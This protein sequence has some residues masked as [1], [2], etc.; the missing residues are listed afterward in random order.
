MADEHPVPSEHARDLVAGGYDTH[1]HA[2][3]DIMQRRIT[4]VDLVARFAAVGMAGFVLKSHYGCTAERAEVV[5]SVAPEADVLGA[6]TLNGPVGGLNP[7]AVE[8]AARQGARV[9][10]MPTVD[11]LNQRTSRAG[12]PPGAKT[13]LWAAVQDDLAAAGIMADPIAVLDDSGEVLPAVRDV[14]AVT[15]RHGMVLATGHLGTAEIPAVVDAAISAGVRTIVITHPEFTSQ[16]MAVAPQRELA[17]RGVLLERCF[18]TPYSGKVSWDEWLSHI[19]EVGPEHSVLS[20]DLGQPFNPPIEDGLALC[21][22]RLLE[23]GFSDEEIHLM[24]VTNSV[25]VAR[26]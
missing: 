20:G 19:R 15:A 22:D 1:V 5:H 8:I 14:C 23:A 17:E 24:A 3:P 26:G 16:Q 13:P 10:W 25:R 12:A 11:S 6:I 21:A 7:L 9:V 2:A 18:S 4:D